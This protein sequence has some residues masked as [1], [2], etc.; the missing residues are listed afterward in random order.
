VQDH[1]EPL[2]KAK[3]LRSRLYLLVMVQS[4]IMGIKSDLF[5]KG[6]QK[7]SDALSKSPAVEKMMKKDSKSLLSKPSDVE[8]VTVKPAT[9]IKDAGKKTIIAGTGLELLT[10]DMP[11]EKMGGYVGMMEGGSV[12]GQKSIQVKKKVFKGVF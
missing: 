1:Q 4:F 6:I 9:K 10:E 7:V 11:A 5:K 12:R 8:M 2:E 3:E